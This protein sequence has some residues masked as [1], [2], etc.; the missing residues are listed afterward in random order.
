[1]KNIGLNDIETVVNNGKKSIESISYTKHLE[2]WLHQ[3]IFNEHTRIT[4]EQCFELIQILINIDSFRQ[5]FYYPLI[6]ALDVNFFR[7]CFFLEGMELLTLK[8]ASKL[9]LLKSDAVQDIANSFYIL[10]L[11]K[12]DDSFTQMFWD[13]PY[14]FSEIIAQISNSQLTKD[15]FQNYYQ[16]FQQSASSLKNFIS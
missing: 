9:A 11:K 5:K 6:E 2:K 10:T 12:W 13:F 1:M 14:Q 4:D 16:K 7:A 15:H 3:Q 8:T